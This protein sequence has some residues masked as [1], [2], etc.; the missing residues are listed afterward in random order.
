MRTGRGA[1]RPTSTRHARSLPDGPRGWSKPTPTSRPPCWNPNCRKR[2]DPAGRPQAGR[3]RS[4]CAAAPAGEA[5]R[6]RDGCHGGEVDGRLGPAR[7]GPHQVRHQPLRRHARAGP[8][9]R[10]VPLLDHARRGRPQGNGCSRTWTPA[11]STSG[12]PT[13]GGWGLPARASRAGCR[14]RPADVS[15]TDAR[16]G[17]MSAASSLRV[18]DNPRILA[19]AP[20]T[21]CSLV[22]CR[23]CCRALS[24]SGRQPRPAW[25][26]RPRQTPP[27]KSGGSG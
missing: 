20:P 6:P 14:A 25:C 10:R 4:G 18:R 21:A 19:G 22:P 17:G 26:R 16:P 9:D 13:R 3:N 15:T 11:G 2:R 12:S 1:L 8:P 7:H 27:H 24:V 23:C 5:A